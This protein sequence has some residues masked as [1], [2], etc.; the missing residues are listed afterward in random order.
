MVADGENPDKNI[1]PIQV[2][3]DG[4]VYVILKDGTD[5]ANVGRFEADDDN[6]GTATKRLAVINLNYVWD[7][8][9]I[10]W[11]RMTQP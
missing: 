2:D 9:N 7:A 3:D 11:V 8:V 6:I 10:R 1:K 5:N 4:N